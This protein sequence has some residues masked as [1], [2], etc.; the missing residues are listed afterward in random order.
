M[1]YLCF[2][3]QKCRWVVAGLT[4]LTF[5]FCCI[6]IIVYICILSSLSTMA[7]T[8]AIQGVSFLKLKLQMTVLK[9]YEFFCWHFQ[10]FSTSCFGYRGQKNF[11]PDLDEL[12]SLDA[13]FIAVTLRHVKYVIHN[14]NFQ[15]IS[16]KSWMVLRQG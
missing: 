8:T 16:Q 6:A 13:K 2:S 7:S 5:R 10:L 9:I 1:I 3:L 4:P 12:R 11:I 15:S 14:R